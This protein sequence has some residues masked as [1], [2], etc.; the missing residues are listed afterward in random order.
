MLA[1]TTRP[2][3]GTGPRL[4]TSLRADLAGMTAEEEVMDERDFIRWSVVHC[5]MLVTGEVDHEIGLS[6]LN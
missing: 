3:A 1:R 4:M 2:C 5:A 6:V